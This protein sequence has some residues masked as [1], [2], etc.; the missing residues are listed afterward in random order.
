[1][2]DKL[3]EILDAGEYSYNNIEET[4]A[5][6]GNKAL[7]IEKDNNKYRLNSIYKPLIEAKKWTEQ[8]EF[9]NLCTSVMMF[10]MGNCIFVK[11]MLKPL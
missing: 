10:G 1:M 7:I 5:R 2:Y 9:H 3:E 11:E 4:D 8:Y 6:D